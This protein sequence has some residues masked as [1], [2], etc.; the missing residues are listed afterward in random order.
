M[1]QEKIKNTLSKERPTYTIHSH[2]HSHTQE[3]QYRFNSLLPFLLSWI[4]PKRYKYTRAVC[5]LYYRYT[6]TCRYSY[7]RLNQSVHARM[8]DPLIRSLLGWFLLLLLLL[9]LHHLHERII[10][11]IRWLLLLLLLLLPQDGEVNNN[12]LHNTNIITIF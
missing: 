4:A 3:N 1:E 2:S 11:M 9:L 12:N 8:P 5:V 6:D 7:V 10:Q